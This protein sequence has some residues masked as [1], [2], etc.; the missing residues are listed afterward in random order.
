MNRI[1]AMHIFVRVAELASFTKAA[2]SL[3][4]PKASASTAVQH[5]E[6]QLGTQLL[7]RTT[8]RVQLT[9]DGQ[10]YYERCKD[11]L[12]DLDELSTMFQQAPQALSGRLRVDTN[13]GVARRV[14]E[15]LP[16]FLREHPGI[17]VE[18]SCTDRRVD[19][20]AEGFDCVVRV[21]TLT[22]SNLIARPLGQYRIVNC[23]SSAYLEE[24]GV[25]QTLEDL[26]HHKLIH[27]VSVLGQR[28][29]GFEYMEG[30]R[31]HYMPMQGVLT[32]NGVE[33]YAS[34]CLAGLGITQTP[35]E[36]VAHWLRSGRLVEVLPQYE[37]EP[38]PVSLLYAH[39]RNLSVRVQVFMDWLANT[40]APYLDRV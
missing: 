24:H 28:P 21:G 25:P 22:D 37:A 11:V 6:A 19:V 35:R 15:H 23:A 36:G 3:G 20:V 17:Q 32:V 5:L 18:L 12:A 13:S 31:C 14:I 39:R 4:L 27:Y 1:E 34:G 2:D 40:L 33:A 10:R 9:Q 30:S 7:H 38:M 16:Q 26:A 8:R 29:P